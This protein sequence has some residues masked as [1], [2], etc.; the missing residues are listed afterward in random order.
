MAYPVAYQVDYQERP[1]RLTTF[2]RLVIAIPWMVVAFF[3]GLLGLVGVVIGWF[4]IVFTGRYPAGAY[5]L[6]SQALRFSTRTNGW[7]YLMTDELPPLDGG[8]R[9]GYPVRMRIPDPLPEYDRLK[10]LLRL[11]LGIPV[12]VMVYLFQLLAGVVGILAWFVIVFTGAL[13]KGLFDVMKMS[14]AYQAKGS[15]YMLLLTETYPPITEDDEPEPAAT[16]PSYG[17]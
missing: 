17:V 7:M 15:A 4:S 5:A 8:E 11:I 10:T 3:W 13:P 14:L 12:Y 2:F 1:N 9:P 16:A 6:V